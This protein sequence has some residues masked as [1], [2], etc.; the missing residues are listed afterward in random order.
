MGNCF[1]QNLTEGTH[2]AVPYKPSKKWQE[3]RLKRPSRR[4]SRCID[5]SRCGR[6]N[7]LLSS[8]GH[9]FDIFFITHFDRQPH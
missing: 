3:T 6:R 4:N 1:G 5:I 2:S 9:S 8:A 7:V